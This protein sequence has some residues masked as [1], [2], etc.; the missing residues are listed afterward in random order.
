MKYTIWLAKIFLAN[1]SEHN[2]KPD[3]I[4]KDIVLLEIPASDKRPLVIASPPNGHALKTLTHL[5]TDT[6]PILVH[7]N[8]LQSS[9]ADKATVMHL[10]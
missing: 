8:M 10:H 2:M 9:D 3:Y 6:D 7:H 1:W 5:L 4:Y